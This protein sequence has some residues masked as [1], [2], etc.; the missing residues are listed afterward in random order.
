MKR[1]L[2]K[3]ALAGG[4][5][6]GIVRLAAACVDVTPVYVAPREAA[7]IDGAPCLSCLRRPNSELG[8]ADELRA[9]EGDS[10]CRSVSDC[11]AENACFE[12]PFMDDKV[13]CTLPCLD[14][15]GI[16]TLRDPTVGALIDILKCGEKGCRAEC[17]IDD[18]GTG[19]PL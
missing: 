17:S 5:A 9:C 8:C 16:Y 1:S 12:Y 4:V 10:R 11:V 7:A 3:V 18:G 13:A 15:A 14:E 6:L 19:L 2:A